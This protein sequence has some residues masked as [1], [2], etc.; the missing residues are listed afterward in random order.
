MITE[1]KLARINELAH[2]SRETS[3]TEAEKTEQALLRREY[4]D[5]V[6]ANLKAQLDMIVVPEEES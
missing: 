3:L 5:A 4:I 2:K 6:K 1:E